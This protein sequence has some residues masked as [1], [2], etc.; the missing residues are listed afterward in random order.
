MKTQI[1]K[2]AKTAD[3]TIRFY[4]GKRIPIWYIKSSV[5]RYEQSQEGC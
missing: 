1:T 2:H 5:I 3:A 4:G